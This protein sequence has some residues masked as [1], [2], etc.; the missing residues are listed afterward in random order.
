V[1]DQVRADEFLKEFSAFEKNGDLPRLVVMLLPQDHTAGT[2][3]EFP[4]P[5]ACVA[6]NDRALGR[7]VEAISQSRYWKE[8][9]IFVTE[10]DAQNGTDHVDG[11]RT[12]GMIISPWVRRNAVDST[13]YTAINMFRTI[14]QILGL[15]PAN[16]F[17]LA[18]E[19]MFPAFTATPDFLPYTA[20]P[21]RIPLDE[22]NPALKALKGL[23]RRLA[24]AS[25]TM[26][27]NEPDAAPEDVLNRAIWHS[28]KGYG[29]AYPAT[30]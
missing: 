28:V 10:D 2:S 6:D 8:S 19:P 29:T 27:F 16:Q 4:T 15:P 26:D 5:R 20:L 11:H 22:M 9:A 23:P 1:P 13:F 18:A 12:V 7:I 14:E 30:R 21:N 25:R 3:P 24:E 17:D